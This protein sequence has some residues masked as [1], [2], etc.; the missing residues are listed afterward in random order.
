MMME[1][2]FQEMVVM[3][4]ASLKLGS[5]AVEEPCFLVMSV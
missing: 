4:V 2:M 5:L 3:L 1:I